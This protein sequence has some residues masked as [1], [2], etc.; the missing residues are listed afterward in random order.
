[1]HHELRQFPRIP[2]EAKAEL[3]LQK[4]SGTPGLR[5]LPVEISTIACKGAG[6]ELAEG[7]AE[8]V[9]PA[10]EAALSLEINGSTITIPARVVWS[11]GGKAGLRLHLNKADRETRAT[12]ASWI[13]PLT[14][15][16]VAKA[17]KSTVRN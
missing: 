3:A 6:L 5:V 9:Q 8:L 15:A 11:A 13:V 12:Y 2:V 16:A 14:N 17:K 4:K 10:I 7:D 1:M